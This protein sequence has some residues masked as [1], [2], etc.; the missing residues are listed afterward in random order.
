VAL[1]SIKA[2]KAITEAQSA[3]IAALESRLAEIEAQGRNEQG[4]LTIQMLASFAFGAGAMAAC[5]V[6]SARRRRRRSH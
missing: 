1:A 5:W 4:V 3:Q 6:Y 2:L